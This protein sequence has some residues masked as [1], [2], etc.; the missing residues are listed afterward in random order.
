MIDIREIQSN[1]G[2]NRYVLFKLF[3]FSYGSGGDL[4]SANKPFTLPLE[5]DPYFK[6]ITFP[7]IQQRQ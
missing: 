1:K 7:E 4:F 3:T 6:K 2:Q 5:T